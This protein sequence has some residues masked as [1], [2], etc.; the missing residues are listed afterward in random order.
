MTLYHSINDFAAA[1]KITQSNCL[2]SCITMWPPFYVDH[3][4]VSK[5]LNASDFT[6]FT[7]LDGKKQTAWRRFPLYYY[8]GD[9]AAGDTN[10]QDIGNAWYMG[11]DPYYTAPAKTK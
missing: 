5:P 4:T 7:R 9:Y 11:I 6:T 2:G 1:G 3:I 10:G 8:S